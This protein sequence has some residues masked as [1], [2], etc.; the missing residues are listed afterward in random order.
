MLGIAE[1]SGCGVSLSVPAE[2]EELRIPM[3]NCWDIFFDPPILFSET[4]KSTK[5]IEIDPIY[6]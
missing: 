4:S 1:L 2:I 6:V 3:R 5:F